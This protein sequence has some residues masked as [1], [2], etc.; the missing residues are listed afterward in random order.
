MRIYQKQRGQSIVEFALILPILMFILIG[1]VYSAMLCHD[2]LALQAIARDSVRSMSIGTAPADIRARY[3]A[4]P[5]MTDI[6]TWSAASAA[7]FSLANDVP[8]TGYVTATATANCTW[9]G[10]DFG[11]GVH[12]Q[13]PA[14][15]QARFTM[16]KEE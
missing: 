11:G 16:R 3:A 15:I 14:T 9:D 10:I 8:V 13:L 1:F 4:N 6:Y 12:L 7:D 2:Y 5:F